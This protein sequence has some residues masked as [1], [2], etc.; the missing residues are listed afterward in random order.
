MPEMRERDDKQS[1][2][3]VPLLVIGVIGG[4]VTALLASITTA[5]AAIAIGG[6]IVGIGGIV[7]LWLRGHARTGE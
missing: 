1:A 6:A 7:F 3:K 5:I 2:G 4:I